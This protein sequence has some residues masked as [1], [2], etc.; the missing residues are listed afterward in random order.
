MAK[1]V[2]I[3]D[4]QFHVRSGKQWYKS[5]NF[6]FDLMYEVY[7]PANHVYVVMVTREDGKQG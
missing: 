3:V 6:T 4:G 7:L 1:N 5:T 2:K